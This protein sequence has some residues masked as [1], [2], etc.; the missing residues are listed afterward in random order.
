MQHLF[1]FVFNLNFLSLSPKR[2]S[3]PIPRPSTSPVHQQSTITKPLTQLNIS[4]IEFAYSFKAPSIADHYNVDDLS[5]GD[6][7][8]NDEH[9]RKI[10]PRWA[11]SKCLL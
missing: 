5:S 6:E 8:D 4:P 10:V 3:S 11:Q 9:P 2:V 1:F 7:T